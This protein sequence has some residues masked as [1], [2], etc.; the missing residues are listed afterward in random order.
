MNALMEKWIIS[1]GWLIEIGWSLAVLR[2][3]HRGLKE[4]FLMGAII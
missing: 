3:Y 1:K 2:L 4:E